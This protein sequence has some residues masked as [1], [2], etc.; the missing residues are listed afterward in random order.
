MC[1]ERVHRFLMAF[2]LAL[3]AG[4]LSQGIHEGI[5]VIYF[6]IGMLFIFGLTNFCPSVWF[7]RKAGLKK[8]G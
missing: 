1:L 6:V 7:M 4:L 8:C 2:V 3:G 5:Y